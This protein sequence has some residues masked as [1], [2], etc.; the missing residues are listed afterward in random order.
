MR[1]ESQQ[2]RCEA[3]RRP[4]R[5][6]DASM[7]SA[8]ERHREHNGDRACGRARGRGLQAERDAA[9]DEDR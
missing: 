7:R 4:S 2:V 5:D 3:R 9:A 1:E 6:V 8:P